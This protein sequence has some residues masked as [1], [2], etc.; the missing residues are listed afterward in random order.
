MSIVEITELVRDAIVSPSLALLLYGSYAR[1]DFEQSSDID[2]LQVTATHTAPYSIGNINVTCYTPGQLTGLARNGSLFARHLVSEALPIDDPTG[3]L[4]SLRSKYVAPKDYR[5]VF[6]EI[7]GAV[8]IVAITNDIFEESPRHYSATASYLLRTYV[9]AKAVELGARSFSM[10]HVGDL[11]G[12]HRPRQR[13]IDL[14]LNHRYSQFYGVV[15]LLF[16]FTGL[17]P[18]DRKESLQAFVANSHGS[19]ELAVI[20]GLRV[21][22]RGNLLTY[23]FIQ[24][25]A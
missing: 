19:F 25:Q 13:L 24:P 1:G 6:Y 9:Y 16:E 14:K 3:F 20:L 5:S 8:P 10:Q 12:D 4:D 17:V 7:S 11:I 2:I 18:F 22:A 23:V 15:N 21:L